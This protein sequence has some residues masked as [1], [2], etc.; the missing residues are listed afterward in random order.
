MRVGEARA[1]EVRHRV[2]L[3]PDD[4]VEDP[5]VGVLEQ[6]ADAVDVVI[7]ADHPDRAVVLEDAPRLARAS[8]G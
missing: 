6:R 3:A 7:A 5:E 1:A 4:V 8:R 2:R